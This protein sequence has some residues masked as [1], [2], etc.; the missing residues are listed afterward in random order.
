VRYGLVDHAELLAEARK[1]LAAAEARIAE[2]EAALRLV[3]DFAWTAV[4]A[5]C[6]DARQELNRRVNI[7]R[8]ALGDK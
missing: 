5:D 3:D 2:L 8:E 1:K 7:C 6:E 4:K